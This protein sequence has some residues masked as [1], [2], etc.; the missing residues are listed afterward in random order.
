[1]ATTETLDKLYLEWSELTK[2]R[3]FREKRLASQIRWLIDYGNSVRNNCGL[4][5]VNKNWDAQ[6][7]TA[8]DTLNETGC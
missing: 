3:T 4:E 2:A 7:K 8:I 5:V 1:M 6:A